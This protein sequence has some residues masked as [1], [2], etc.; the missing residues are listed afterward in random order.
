MPSNFSVLVDTSEII[1][2]TSLNPVQRNPLFS[3]LI[4]FP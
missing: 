3:V 1:H 4:L 2:K